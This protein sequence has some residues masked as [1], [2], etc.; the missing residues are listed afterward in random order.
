MTK[1][2]AYYLSLPY[3]IEVVHNAQNGGEA[4]YWFARVRELPG[5]MTETDRFEQLN[6][7]IQDA[8][9]TWLQDA[10]ADGDAIPEPR[11]VAAYSGKFSIHIPQ[12]LHR[13]LEETAVQEGVSLDTFV[14]AA[15]ARAVGQATAS[16]T[17]V[18][19]SSTYQLIR[20]QA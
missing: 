12:S 1:N 5:C 10:L 11:P 17:E 13:D 8:M 20:E 15:L 14:T 9:T 6:E 2:L 7:M 18:A 4:D 3:T 19:R 16:R